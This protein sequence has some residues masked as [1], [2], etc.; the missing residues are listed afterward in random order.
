MPTA[1]DS[2]PGLFSLADARDLLV[3]GAGSSMATMVPASWDEKA[4]SALLWLSPQLLPDEATIRETLGSLVERVND[5]MI[6]L[7]YGDLLSGYAEGVGDERKAELI[8][9]VGYWALEM[10]QSALAG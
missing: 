8:S 4:A 9:N 5:E 2:A 3:L 1:T 10:A 6:S 7:A